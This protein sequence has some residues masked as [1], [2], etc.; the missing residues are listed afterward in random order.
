M[1]DS[2]SVPPNP[3]L[4]T[5]LKG[6]DCSL[7]LMAVQHV[8]T[9]QSSEKKC[10]SNH[11]WQFTANME[12]SKILPLVNVL[13][14]ENRQLLSGANSIGLWR[15]NYQ[16]SSLENHTLYRMLMKLSSECGSGRIQ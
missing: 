13:E 4:C 14:T 6:A 8:W 11:S 7:M 1:N 5:G 9:H 12:Y 15:L 16:C 10:L 3:S 2:V